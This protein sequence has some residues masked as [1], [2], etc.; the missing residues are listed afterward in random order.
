MTEDGP[1]RS[2]VA[3]QRASTR[4]IR[5]VHLIEGSLTGGAARGAYWLHQGLRE[6]GLDSSVVTDSPDRVGDPHVA[7]STWRDEGLRGRVM[8][9]VAPVV[10]RA[11]VL[12]Y[13]HRGPAY[14][15]MGVV[16]RDLQRLAIVRDSDVVHVH[17]LAGGFVDPCDLARLG[18]PVVWTL[19]DMWPITGGCH[20]AMDCERFT[21]GCGRC[22]QLGSRFVHDLSWW[23]ARRKRRGWPRTATI[24][25]QSEWISA[26]AR[27]S[28]VATGMEIVTIG[29]GVSCSTFFP[30]ER[31]AARRALG[32]ADG[33]KKVI[34]VGAQNVEDFY[35]G[36]DALLAAL[37]RLDRARYLVVVFGRGGAKRIAVLGFEVRDLGFLK[38]D[39]ALR[40]AYSA[41]DVFVAPSRT[42]TFGKTIAEAMACGRPV[43]CF[44]ATGPRD[45]VD[46]RTNGYRATPY[47]PEDL[48]AGIEWVCADEE[49]WGALADSARAKIE[50]SFDVHVIARGYHA[51]YQR[52]LADERRRSGPKP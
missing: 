17:W 40:N 38:D 13:L 16:G 25:G 44:D 46:H 22:P 15:T 23:M 32:I 20:F 18:K 33:A 2:E 35:K 42:E 5:V 49:R 4:S 26:E 3:R 50:H 45:I 7:Y 8:A 47:E 29:N 21:H 10:E 52:V 12:A 48:A 31:D 41:A 14:F 28:S 51:L 11:P 19:R 43:V 34:L 30:V 37:D 27:R 39:A 9:L 36:F 6:I 24:V 1:I